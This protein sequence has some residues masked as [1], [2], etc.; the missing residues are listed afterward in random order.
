MG[1]RK[2]TNQRRTRR[3][4]A[5]HYEQGISA[6]CTNCRRALRR[7]QTMLFSTPG[8]LTRV[9]TAKGS[10]TDGDWRYYDDDEN[11]LTKA[12][13]EEAQAGAET[14][15]VSQYCSARHLLRQW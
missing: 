10:D 7:P 3:S 9:A 8:N 14:S 6:P 4:K 12:E 1:S 2:G 11:A 13:Q 15:V 5:T